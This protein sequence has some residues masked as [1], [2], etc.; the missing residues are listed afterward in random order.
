[1]SFSSVADS[2]NHSLETLEQIGRY[3]DFMLSIKTLA[4][5]GCGKGEELKWWA[6]RTDPETNEPLKIDCTDR[7]S[8]V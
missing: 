5:M 1:M 8:V 3:D 2:Y 6:T 4:D 7:K